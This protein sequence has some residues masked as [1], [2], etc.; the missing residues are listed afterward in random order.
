MPV[1]SFFIIVFFYLLIDL[2]TYFGLKSLLGSKKETNPSI[3]LLFSLAYLAISLWIL[4]AFYVMYGTIKADVYFRN[5]AYAPYLGIALTAL[6]SK[7]VFSVGLLLQDLGRVIVGFIKYLSPPSNVVHKENKVLE[8]GAPINQPKLSPV[9]DGVNK[10]SIPTRRRFLSLMAAGIASIPLG[11]MW[12]GLTRGKYNFVVKRISLDFD[13]LPAAFD[14]F[15]IVQFSDLH[16]GGLD[17]ISEVKRGL[18]LINEQNPDLVL[19]TGDLVNSVL[20]E[21]DPYIDIMKEVK[22]KFGQYAVLG[23]HDYHGAPPDNHPKSSAYWEAFNGRFESMD[24]KL[25]NNEQVAIRK[26]GQHIRLLGVENWGTGDWFPQKGD[27]DKALVGCEDKDF[28]VLMSHDPTH[29]DLKVL[30]HQRSID[31]TLSGHT[32]G[33]QFGLDLPGFKWSSV[34]YRY[35]RWMGLYQEAKQYLYVNR[36]FGYSIFP[37]RI[38]MW[39]EITVLELKSKVLKAENS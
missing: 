26:D 25:L 15:K 22:G 16:A 38:G 13:N 36:G 3:S 27:L 29:W 18:D 19:F 20:E 21:I 32:H 12:H 11:T 34:K 2:Y 14:G 35:K 7:S 28:C 24:F 37:G 39:P 6:I 17:D 33:G 5:V 10:S 31:L 9:K 23:N 8:I 30:P 1:K 4:H